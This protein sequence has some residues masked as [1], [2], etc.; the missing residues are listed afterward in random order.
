MIE[1]TPHGFD[2]G[3]ARSVAVGSYRKMS[4][5][6]WFAAGKAPNGFPFLPEFC[7]HIAEMAA[8]LYVDDPSDRA[9]ASREAAKKAV[10]WVSGSLAEQNKG[11]VRRSVSKK[12]PYLGDMYVIEKVTDHDDSGQRVNPLFEFLVPDATDEIVWQELLGRMKTE[13]RARLAERLTE[14]QMQIYD[15]LLEMDGDAGDAAKV[16]K[17]L[18]VRHQYVY[19]VLAKRIRPEVEQIAPEIAAELR[20]C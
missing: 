13:V 3:A 2:E 8:H 14:K 18:G 17:M 19:Y 5:W 20:K 6:G 15:A 16:A 11:R 7:D 9:E 4:S 10:Y 12:L 1:Y